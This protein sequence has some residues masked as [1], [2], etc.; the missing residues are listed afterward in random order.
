MSVGRYCRGLV[1][2]SR[3]DDILQHT[4]LSA[5]GVGA[6][7][8]VRQRTGSRGL[9]VGDGPPEAA[10]P[11]EGADSLGSDEAPD[12]PDEDSTASSPSIDA[13]ATRE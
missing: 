11:P 5:I 8:K 13:M 2:P 12:I 7:P 6:G 9:I 1:R 4:F 3:V 10:D